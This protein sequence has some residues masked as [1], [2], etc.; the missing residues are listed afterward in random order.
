MHAQFEREEGRVRDRR[1]R[2]AG[3]QEGEVALGVL[4]LDEQAVA[5][6]AL[7]VRVEVVVRL[8]EVLLAARIDDQR[9]NR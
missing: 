9:L 5:E 2:A 3:V 1:A 7:V 8:A 4:R 6:H